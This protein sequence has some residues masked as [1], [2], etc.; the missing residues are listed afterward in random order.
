MPV[1]A[2]RRG[3]GRTDMRVEHQMSSQAGERSPSWGDGQKDGVRCATSE[4]VASAEKREV[5][6]KRLTACARDLSDKKAW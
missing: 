3:P 2:S 4:W 1:W 6:M 5:L